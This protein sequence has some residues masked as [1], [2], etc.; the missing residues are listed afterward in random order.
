MGFPAVVGQA[1]RAGDCN[2]VDFNYWLNI[3]Q[4]LSNS[5]I[6]VKI[7]D[8]VTFNGDFAVGKKIQDSFNKAQASSNQDIK[9]LLAELACEVAKV[10][11]QLPQ[12][13]A[14]D[15]ADDLETFTKEAIKP[16][17]KPSRW[18]AVADRIGE[19]VE[20]AAQVGAAG[21]AL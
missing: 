10:A 19:A 18:E 2:F 14:T 20:T 15:L 11:E 12:D 21:V 9:T 8:N 1:D 7:G 3:V 16:Q 5:K 6:E 17:P 4:M 13:D